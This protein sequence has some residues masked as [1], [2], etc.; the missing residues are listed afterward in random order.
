[1][2]VV[3]VTMRSRRDKVVKTPK[4]REAPEDNPLLPASADSEAAKAVKLSASHRPIADVTK[5][6]NKEKESD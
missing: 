4:T 6:K 1:M 3:R 5:I 2:L